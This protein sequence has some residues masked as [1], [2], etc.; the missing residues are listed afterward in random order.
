MA[1]TREPT[2]GRGARLRA[3]STGSPFRRARHRSTCS[4]PAIFFV[5]GILLL[6]LAREG[7]GRLAPD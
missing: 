1:T 3:I 7:R 4:G 5:I 2:R 6:P